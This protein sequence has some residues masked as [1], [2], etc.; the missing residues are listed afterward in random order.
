MVQRFVTAMPV[1]LRSVSYLRDLADG[2]MGR[3]AVPPQLLWHNSDG[4]AP[5]QPFVVPLSLQGPLRP[6][7]RFQA[8]WRR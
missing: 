6:V 3:G 7:M 1:Y 8:E 4:V 2:V 5:D